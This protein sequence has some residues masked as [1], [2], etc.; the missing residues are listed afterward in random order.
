MI[1]IGVILLLLLFLVG[2]CSTKT[3]NSS[4]TD[5]AISGDRSAVFSESLI[6]PG[7]ITTVAGSRGSFAGSKLYGIVATTAKLD[8]TRGVIVDAAGNFYIST[9][10]H[11]IF[12]V[13]ASSNLISVVAGTS[14]AGFSGD[15]AAAT[16][17]TLNYPRGMDF[18]KFGNIYVADMSNHRVRKISVSTG[19]ITTVAGIGG[20][21]GTAADNVAAT[22]TRLNFP[23]DVAVDTFGNIYIA[24]THN[25]RVRKVTASTGIISA[26]AGTGGTRPSPVLGIAA[27]ASTLY[28][29]SSIAIDT[30]GNVFISDTGYNSIYKVTASTGL[31]SLVIGTNGDD[32]AGL[33]AS[34]DR[35]N[36]ITLD[37]QGNIFYSDFNNNRIRK[38]TKGSGALTTLVGGGLTPSGSCPSFD[39][40]GDNRNAT[41]VSLCQPHGVAVDMAG[42]VFLCDSGHRV[43]RKVT[44]AIEDLGGSKSPS[45]TPASFLTEP[46]AAAPVASS[47]NNAKS[48]STRLVAA[49]QYVTMTFF[50]ALLI[51]YLYQD[52]KIFD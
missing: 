42:N 30:S 10:N 15:A 18:D 41:Q 34:S 29:P 37:A 4:S 50:M 23:R 43:V 7:L 35:P 1:R 24:D 21:P 39:Y 52:A 48:S 2:S 33:T 17:A 25:Y 22:S 51:L 16:A 14:G 6:P 26:F 45:V 31:I 8:T 9:D 27:T 46:P 40:G 5:A 49:S 36:C 12:K 44:Y 11:R 19:I 28:Y 3:I 13:T 32:T 38:I 20:V 47:S